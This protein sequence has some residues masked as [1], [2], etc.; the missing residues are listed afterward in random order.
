MSDLQR[1]ILEN[2]RIISRQLSGDV[3][4]QLRMEEEMLHLFIKHPN[5]TLAVKSEAME[6]IKEIN[7]RQTYE[8]GGKTQNG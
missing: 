5:Y 3:L 6:R 4:T 8:L 2:I 7:S 1:T